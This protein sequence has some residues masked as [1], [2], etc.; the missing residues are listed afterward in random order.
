MVN[1]FKKALEFLKSKPEVDFVQDA[2][3][4]KMDARNM[5]RELT[6]CLCNSS[7]HQMIANYFENDP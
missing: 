5:E 3:D 4:M 7:E 2:P 1:P 6:I